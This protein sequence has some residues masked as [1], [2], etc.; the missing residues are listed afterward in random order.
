MLYLIHKSHKKRAHIWNG[1]DTVCRLHS[2][3]GIPKS[4]YRVADEP[5]PREVCQLCGGAARYAD[6]HRGHVRRWN[7]SLR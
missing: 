4:K 6:D 7:L 2:T 3:G 5:G 1:A